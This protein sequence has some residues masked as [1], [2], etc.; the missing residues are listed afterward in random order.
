MRVAKGAVVGAGESGWLANDDWTN[1][2]WQPADCL[3]VQKE[4]SLVYTFHPLNAQEFPA[5]SDFPALFRRTLKLRLHARKAGVQISHVE[6][7]TNSTWAKVELA[8]EWQSL[9]GEPV[10]WNGRIEAFNGE[11]ARV[12][13][14]NQGARLTAPLQWQSAVEGSATAGVIATVRY[15]CNE[16]AN[17]FDR[18]IVTV[19][20]P[21]FGHSLEGFSLQRG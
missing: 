8:V 16:D 15:A 13:P 21:V 20:S 5:E 9:T 10:D 7:Y 14:V 11:I 17:S 6:A 3:V 1:G 12:R 19:R 2:R 18:T 4:H